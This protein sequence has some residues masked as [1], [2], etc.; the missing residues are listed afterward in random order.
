MP[1]HSADNH[2]IKAIIFDL[3]N[4]LVDFDHTIAAKKASKFSDKSPKEIFSIFFNSELISLFEEGKV[5]PIEFFSKIKKLLNLKLDYDKFVPIWNEIFFLTARNH[6]V[7]NLAK[8]L[9]KHYVLALLSNIN[10]LHFEYLKNKF[11]VFDAFHHIVTSFELGV[12]KPKPEIYQ[13]TIGILKVKPKEAFYTDDRL[14]LIDKSREMGIN[15]FV[16]KNP[17]QLKKD[18]LE[19]GINID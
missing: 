13:R 3:G 10:I 1:N 17:M 5:T 4:V 16:F 11:P 19:S 18:L 8:A 9:K 12:Q 14:E 7:Y 15:S 6:E 2:V